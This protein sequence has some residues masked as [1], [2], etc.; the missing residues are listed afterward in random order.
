MIRHIY[1]EPADI[2]CN[3]F[4]KQS[5]QQQYLVLAAMLL[6]IIGAMALHPN[7]KQR[8]CVFGLSKILCLYT[9]RVLNIK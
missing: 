6:T 3:M 5:L 4:K 8:M 7:E 2:K 9:E 1:I